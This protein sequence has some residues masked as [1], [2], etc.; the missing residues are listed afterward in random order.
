MP[1][2]NSQKT[3]ALLLILAVALPN[4]KSIPNGESFTAPGRCNNYMSVCT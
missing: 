4:N 3:A 1:S 2:K